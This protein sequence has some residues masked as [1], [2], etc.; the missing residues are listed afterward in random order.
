M[1]LTEEPK[2]TVN[3]HLY[4]AFSVPVRLPR[5]ESTD[6]WVSRRPRVTLGFVRTPRP[7]V[8]TALLIFTTYL[9]RVIWGVIIIAIMDGKINM[10][11]GEHKCQQVTGR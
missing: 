7:L 9:R 2:R 8:N 6:Q 11:I 4:E 5:A 1:A 3:S 10:S